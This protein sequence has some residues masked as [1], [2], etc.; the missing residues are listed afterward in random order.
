MTAVEKASGFEARPVD[1]VE[2]PGVDCNSV[3]LG[4]RYVKRVHPAMRAEGVL[5][6][7]GT[8]GIGGQ[9]V[10]AAEQFEILRRYRQM[11]DAL[12]R[13]DGAAAL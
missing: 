9:R 2:A 10:L 6:D 7:A 12:L 3:G 13:A 5:G 4:T 11:E 8:E 1:I